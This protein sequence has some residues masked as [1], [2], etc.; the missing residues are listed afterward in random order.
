MA[1]FASSKK[2]APEYPVYVSGSPVYPV[3]LPL[4]FMIF[5]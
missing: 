3:V 5:F 1:A 2:E 4:P